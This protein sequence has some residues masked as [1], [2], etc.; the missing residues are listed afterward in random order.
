MAVPPI[1][2]VH[3]AVE[4]IPN[5]SPGGL[6]WQVYHSVRNAVVRTC[7]E[8]G[9]TGPMGECPIVVGPDRPPV[10]DWPPG[11]DPC[12]FFVVDD[13]Y[14]DERY[15]YMEVEPTAALTGEWLAR[16]LAVLRDHPGW[17]IGISNV[18]E[19]YVLLFADRIMVT[20]P[21]L[22]GCGDAAAVLRALRAGASPSDPAAGGAE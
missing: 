10:R 21:A 1:P 11:D 22:A 8:F 9:P 6:P 15:I 16:M 4:R 12:D 13:Q 20:G 3:Y 19:G 5:P 14:N 17:G 18:A 2:V 7:R